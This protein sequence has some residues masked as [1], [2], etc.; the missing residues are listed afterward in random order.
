MNAYLNRA[1]VYSR[2]DKHA[3]A[4]ADLDVVAQRGG[5][6][7]LVHRL[8]GSLLST[9]G[10]QADALADYER[11]IAL[12]PGDVLAYTGRALTYRRMGK[13]TDSLNDLNRALQLSPSNP[14]A[15][16]QRASLHL[17]QG[18]LKE[19]QGD[20][21]LAAKLFAAPKDGEDTTGTFARVLAQVFQGKYAEGLEVAEERVK[22]NPKDPHWLYD[23]ACAFAIAGEVVAQ[24]KQ[25][26]DRE[27]RSQRYKARALD[28]I[29]AA[30]ASGYRNLSHLRSDYDFLTLAKEPRFLKLTE[31]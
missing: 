24:D 31:K 5:N 1:L 13:L 4:I 18:R 30:V 23:M 3:E 21:E 14:N 7:A 22:V 6:V 12:N 28:L 19:A 26:T 29:E 10:K 17:G 25:L 20:Y 8:R 15:Y 11:A 9:Q 27:E 2:I 16:L